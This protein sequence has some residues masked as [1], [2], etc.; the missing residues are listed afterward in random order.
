[1][2]GA[3][4]SHALR[5]RMHLCCTLAPL[6]ATSSPL[7]SQ[8]CDP[9]PAPAAPLLLR[10]ISMGLALMVYGREEGADALIEQMSHEQ[11]PIQRYGAMFALGLAYR[12]TD[13]NAAIQKL[14]H[15]AVTDVSD[16]VRR[17]A[18]V[19]WR[20]HLVPACW[21]ATCVPAVTMAYV[22]A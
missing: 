17:C 21:A 7:I 18:A 4:L 15:F 10:G 11:D 2:P 9:L 6:P 22:K 8:C 13:N 14:L 12:G 19:S 3:W 1:M 5:S 20:S 16:D